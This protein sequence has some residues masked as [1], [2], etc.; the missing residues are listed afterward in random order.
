MTQWHPLICVRRG[1]RVWF[2]RGRG[3]GFE[4][5]KNYGKTKGREAYLVFVVARMA[6]VLPSVQ[7]QRPLLTGIVKQLEMK[8]ETCAS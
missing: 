3:S 4:W 7:L 1:T 6:A 5:I 2:L 8:I